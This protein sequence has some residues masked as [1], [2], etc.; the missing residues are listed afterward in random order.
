MW[1]MIAVRA[2]AGE[3]VPEL[4]FPDNWR[5]S[6]SCESEWQ[7]LLQVLE[8]TNAELCAAVAALD[9]ERLRDQVP[10]RDYSLYILLHGVVQHNLYHAGQIAILKM[11]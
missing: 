11:K 9:D 6:D 8:R 4:P 2:I 10:G 3:P 5:T 7:E 1:Q